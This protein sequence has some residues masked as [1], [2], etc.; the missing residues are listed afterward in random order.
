MDERS[1][2]SRI[3]GGMCHLTR[4]L[5]SKLMFYVIAVCALNHLDKFKLYR[6][7]LQYFHQTH[8]EVF[9]FFNIV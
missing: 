6:T 8:L 4:R 9:D 2:E 1:P 7:M 5:E 3:I